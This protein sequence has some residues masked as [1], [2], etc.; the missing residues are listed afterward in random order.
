MAAAAEP[1]PLTGAAKFLGTVSLALA[2]FMNVLDTSI[3]N[4]SLP[5]I[6]GNLGVSTTQVT[7]VITSFGVANAIAVPLTGWLSQRFGAVRLFTASIVLF[8][9]ASL[10]C[11]LST[12]LQ[13]LIVF[14]VLQGAVAGPMIPLSQALLLSSFSRAK[15][16]S[17][18]A[19]WAMTTLVAPV[20]GPLLGG[21]ITDNIS[22]PWI[23]YINIPVGVFAAVVTW[24]IYRSRETERRKLPIDGVGLGLLI[25]WVGSLQVMLD[26]GE[27]LDWFHSSTIV[28]LAVTAAIVFCVFLVWELVD[29]AHPIVDLRLF[30]RRNFWTGT[31]AFA[32]GYGVFFGNVVVLPLWLQQYMDY[33]ATDAGMLTAPVGILALLLSPLVGRWVGKVDQRWLATVAFVI[34]AV[35]LYMRT[36]YNTQANFGFLVVPIIVQGAAMAFFFVPLVSLVLSGLTPDRIPAAS[37]LSNFARIVSG[38]FGTSIATTL[39]DN[40]AILHHAQLTEYVN[41]SSVAARSYVETLQAQGLSLSQAGAVINRNIDVQSHLLAANDL[42]WLSAILF[43][44]MVGVIWLARPSKSNFSAGAVGGA[45]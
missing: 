18:L 35:S 3:A 31:L 8:S 2:T 5:T 16:G 29:N 36:S 17:A 32:L 23:F 4:V 30:K 11:G 25:V 34:F 24:S 44:L 45:H 9:I 37:G 41:N 21:W 38:S 43:L 7:W 42:F 28:A 1:A 6:G 20:T 39:W 40:R 19:I 26:K 15:A 12:S 33:T 10:L 14:R 13:E 27:E 22:W